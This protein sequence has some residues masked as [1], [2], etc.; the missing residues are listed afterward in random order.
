MTRFTREFD[1]VGDRGR[2]QSF[3]KTAGGFGRND[4]SGC[5]GQQSKAKTQVADLSVVYPVAR[6]TVQM[7]SM[8]GLIAT[9]GNL[10]VFR[11]PGGRSGVRWGAVT[12]GLIASSKVVDAYPMKALG[13]T[14]VILE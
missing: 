13:L 7:L 4:A 1:G 10:S 9:R 12:G 3:E 6:G 11:Q 2:G 14:P 8:I 5:A